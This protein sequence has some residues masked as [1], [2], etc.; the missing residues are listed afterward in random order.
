MKIPEVSKDTVASLTVSMA[1]DKRW[2]K[3]QLIKMRKE[4]KLLH[5]LIKT[6][7]ASWKNQTEVTGY[8]KGLCTMY[9]LIQNQLEAN[10]WN[11][12]YSDD[13]D[14][15]DDTKN[16][17]VKCPCGSINW[18]ANW[19]CPADPANDKFNCKDCGLVFKRHDSSNKEEK[20]E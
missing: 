19:E 16:I 18:V 15:D 5:A 12:F 7:H 3:N 17:I 11:S 4:N 14:D 6:A 8:I 2:F 9:A 10:E 20:D 13:D 1:H